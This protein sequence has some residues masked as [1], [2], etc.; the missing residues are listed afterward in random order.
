MWPTTGESMSLASGQVLRLPFDQYQRY[1]LVSETVLRFKQ[2]RGIGRPVRLLDVGGYPGVIRDF[3]SEDITVLDMQPMS[4]PWHIVGNGTA[5][6]FADGTFDVVVT[7]DALEHV[8]DVD[9]DRF[10]TELYRVSTDLIVVCAP[11]HHPLTV[12]A[13]RILFE[14]IKIALGAEHQQLRE[15]LINGLPSLQTT[16]DLLERLG[17]EVRVIPSGQIYN[18]VKM[19]LV[20]HFLLSTPSAAE[21]G[22]LV[23][24]F[25]NE[26]FYESDQRPPSYRKVLIALKGR[27]DL[28][29]RYLLDELANRAIQPA[30]E[31]RDDNEAAAEV[32]FISSL[33]TL[34]SLSAHIGALTSELAGA[35]EH[36]GTLTSELAGAKEHI[37][38]LTSEL[39]AVTSELSDVKRGRALRLLN[40]IQRA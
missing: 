6:P 31:Q 33:L 23:D 7:L 2:A 9:R 17:T 18:W 1:R 40:W 36:I 39:T 32:T 24:E 16:V 22:V 5:L 4:E 26:Q 15:H 37:G 13:E 12:Q 34:S 19:M 3:L 8:P 14:Y 10:V 35:K 20:K 30:G 28:S 11:F 38:A 27:D 21:L 25:Y 29:C